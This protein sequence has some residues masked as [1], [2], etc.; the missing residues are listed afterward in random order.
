MQLELAPGEEILTR[1]VPSSQCQIAVTNQRI[2]LWEWKNGVESLIPL[3]LSDVY[4]VEVIEKKGPPRPLAGALILSLGGAVLLPFLVTS[5][6]NLRDGIRIYQLILGL[7]GFGS[8]LWGLFLIGR[9]LRGALFPD[10]VLVFS[11][12]PELRVELGSRLP[13]RVAEMVKLVQQLKKRVG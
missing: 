1:V 12:S 7:L 2:I 11:G 6:T 5:L 9:Y 8:L 13:H 3:K 10:L 4:E